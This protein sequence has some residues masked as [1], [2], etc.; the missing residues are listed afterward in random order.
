MKNGNTSCCLNFRFTRTYFREGAL[1][2]LRSYLF[3]SRSNRAGPVGIIAMPNWN[4]GWGAVVGEREFWAPGSYS[5]TRKRKLSMVIASTCATTNYSCGT[6]SIYGQMHAL[7]PISC[8]RSKVFFWSNDHSVACMHKRN[9]GRIF[10][11]TNYRQ[12]GLSRCFVLREKRKGKEGLVCLLFC[13]A[14][15]SGGH[16]F[17]CFQKCEKMALLLASCERERKVYAACCCPFY[18]GC[19]II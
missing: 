4:L 18:Y 3:L 15:E 19:T 17:L 16:S 10:A 8:V 7:T 9:G 14:K 2:W 11:C 1:C 5:C 6:R 13:S 12:E